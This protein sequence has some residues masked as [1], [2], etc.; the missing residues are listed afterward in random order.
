M[1][2]KHTKVRSDYP[3]IINARARY[4]NRCRPGD[5]II[6]GR[7]D[8]LTLMETSQLE[9]KEIDRLMKDEG[10]ALI[11]S[12]NSGQFLR[13]DNQ[14]NFDRIQN[15]LESRRSSM[16]ENYFDEMP[17]K[18]ARQYLTRNKYLKVSKI[19]WLFIELHIRLRSKNVFEIT[20]HI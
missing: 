13:L 10:C 17:R 15:R 20:V 2:K 14:F 4:H 16:P 7:N 6:E 8:P 19:E 3:P 1:Y 18:E 5:A 11:G 12:R 9:K